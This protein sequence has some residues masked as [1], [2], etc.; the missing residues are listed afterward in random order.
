LQAIGWALC[1]EVV[2]RDGKVLNPRMTNYIIPTALD[3]PPFH[4][5]LVEAPFSYG[6]GGGAK[7][8]GELPMDGG[9]PAIAA[10]VEHATGLSAK[11]MPLSPERLLSLS[12]SNAQGG[13]QE[14][15]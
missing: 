15:S 4:T 8:I 9:G 7:G 2:W 13:R 14:A 12:L 1:E 5:S 10:A 11:E 3:A 6:P